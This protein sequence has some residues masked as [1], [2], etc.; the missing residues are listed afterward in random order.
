MYRSSV[1][2]T[3]VS[4]DPSSCRKLFA[5]FGTAISHTREQR[6][7]RER[8]DRHSL[9]VK[10]SRRSF[11]TARAIPSN[12]QNTAPLRTRNC[13]RTL[14]PFANPC[15]LSTFPASLR[16]KLLESPPLSHIRIV[17]VLV[18]TSHVDNVRLNGPISG[19]SSAAMLTRVLGNNAIR[20]VF[21]KGQL[22]NKMKIKTPATPASSI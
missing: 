4:Y 18:A 6:Q 1:A 11:D 17:A 8:K 15:Q 22:K 20:I 3:S 7:A 5:S 16:E 2:T 13:A 19:T 9:A 21:A 12:S 14:G 10:P